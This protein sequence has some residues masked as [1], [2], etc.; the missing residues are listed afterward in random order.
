MKVLVTGSNGLCGS[1]IYEESL[2]SD[3]D[4]HFATRSDGDLT[5]PE[6]VRDLFGRIK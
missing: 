5:K 6:E 1:A 4:F 2:G 3:H